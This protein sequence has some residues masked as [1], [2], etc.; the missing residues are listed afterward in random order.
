MATG[1]TEL[2]T[3]IEAAGYY[4]E[5]VA[6]GG[7]AAVAGEHV[8][9]HLVHH[10]P[11]FDHDEVRRHVT[12]VVL[13]P[14]RIVVAHTD[15]HPPDDLLPAPYTATT[16][17]SVALSSV[18]SVVVQRMVAHPAPDAGQ[19]GGGL[20][21]EAVLTVA[22]GAVRRVDMEPAQCADPECEADHGY[23]GTLTADDFSMRVSAAADG[24][25]AVQRLLAFART[26]SD[27][28]ARL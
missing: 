6:E 14:T 9:E 4:P 25:D 26:L 12:V 5:A 28:T 23:A 15:E 11:T 20:P 2:R 16:T 3:A 24:A 18:R 27:S 7:E 13:T 10:E 8:V 22:W 19:T 17:E 1:A 21:S